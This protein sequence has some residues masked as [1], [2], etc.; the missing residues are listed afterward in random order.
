[1]DL[2]LPG[3]VVSWLESCPVHQNIGGFIPS[4]GAYLGCRLD[5]PVCVGGG[6][7]GR[8]V[9]G[10]WGKQ[11]IGVFLFPILSIINN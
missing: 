1:M 10:T 11:P 9:S 6:E 4:Q 5:G 7:G 8:K 3:S 2:Y